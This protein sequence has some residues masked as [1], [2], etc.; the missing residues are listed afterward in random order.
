MKFK[1]SAI[2]ILYF[3]F[4]QEL[5]VSYRDTLSSRR[6]LNPLEEAKEQRH[7]N[8]WSDI[9]KCIFLD[10]FLQHPKDFRKIASFL[11]NKSVHDCISFYYD[12]KQSVPYKRALREH[13]KRKKRRGDSVKWEATIQAAISVGAKVN[14][15][16]S[17]EKPLIFDLPRN[18]LTFHTRYFHP[19]KREIFDVISGDASPFIEIATRQE[20]KKNSHKK[21]SSL[22]NNLFTLD[23]SKRKYLRSFPDYSIKNAGSGSSDMDSEKQKVRQRSDSPPVRPVVKP[24]KT[25]IIKIQKWSTGEKTLF[26]ENFEKVGKEWD[27]LSEAIGTKTSKQVKQ[28]Y[29]DN[30]KYVNKNRIT[31][32]TEVV[33]NN[34]V[35]TQQVPTSDPIVEPKQDQVIKPIP[36]SETTETRTVAHGFSRANVIA[37]QEQQRESVDQ[38]LQSQP[39]QGPPEHWMHENNQNSHLALAIE[40]HR[41][42]QLA[43][44]LSQSQQQQ[45]LELQR[46]EQQRR[47]M[48]RLQQQHQIQNL[49]GPHQNDF[50][51]HQHQQQMM[52]AAQLVQ[53]RQQQQ[54]QQSLQDYLEGKI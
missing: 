16:I 11:K 20:V 42:Q 3:L 36:T 9:E 13:S 10:R 49:L 1:K 52:F 23:L 38:G 17:S 46:Q 53:A 25:K 22:A 44:Q 26:H 7:T 32:T 37:M 48:H 33:A 50:T 29:V 54:Q 27:V 24:E 45:F 47:Q 51:A 19:M 43:Q 39:T 12:S 31:P 30:K 5:H 34:N 40:H 28:F 35:E 6:V 41:Q 8:P 14:V 18:D 15:G 2:L 4:H 21:K